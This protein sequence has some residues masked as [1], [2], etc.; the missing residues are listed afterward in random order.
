MTTSK[1]HGASIRIFLVDGTPHGLRVVERA[2]W[3]GSCLAFAR[4]DYAQARAR[5]EVGRTGVYVLVG[6]DDSG[7]R[8]QRVYVGEADEVR[9]RLDAHQKEKDFWTSGLVLT[10]T[11]NS[12][13]KA[14]VR[15]LEARLLAVA[16]AVDMA[17]LDNSTAPPVPHLAEAEVAD[18]E[19]YLENALILLP[20]VGVSVFEA[21]APKQVTPVPAAVAGTAPAV[22]VPSAGTGIGTSLATPGSSG[23]SL[24]PSTTYYFKSAGVVAEAV[25]DAQGFIVRAGA[26]TSGATGALDQSYAQMRA[27]LES[28]GVLVPHS[29]GGLELTKD[30]TFASASAA[31][32]VLAGGNRN[33]RLMWKDKDGRTLRENQEQSVS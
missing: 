10:T 7:Q 8:A 23:T 22:P 20:L 19:S 14:H 25:D 11:N 3:T 27:N 21:A 17:S 9:V 31:A 32:S 26:L 24:G 2:G 16:R 6:P 29:S 13:N 15:Y 1:A 4:A 18:M 12:L 5:V 33:G 28:Q 30:Y